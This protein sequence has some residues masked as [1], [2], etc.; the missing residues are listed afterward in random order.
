MENPISVKDVGFFCLLRFKR[1][2]E[3]IFLSLSKQKKSMNMKSICYKIVICVVVFAGI[4]GLNRLKVVLDA[5]QTVMNMKS[6]S[7]V[8]SVVVEDGVLTE[9]ELDRINYTY[10]SISNIATKYENDEEDFL[11]YQSILKEEMDLDVYLRYVETIY[12]L[13]TYGGVQDYFETNE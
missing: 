11:R 3:K 1:Y 4:L 9:E 2:S 13:N 7:D 6:F 10:M 5:K 12:S 8:V